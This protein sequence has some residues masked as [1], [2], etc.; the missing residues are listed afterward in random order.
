MTTITPEEKRLTEIQDTIADECSRLERGDDARLDPLWPMLDEMTRLTEKLDTQGIVL[1]EQDW[2]QANERRSYVTYQLSRASSF[3]DVRA[4]I[5][6]AREKRDLVALYLIAEAYPANSVPRA[7]A[8]RP[9]YDT[10]ATRIKI[11][12]DA[13]RIE[14]LRNLSPEQ[15]AET[16]ALRQGLPTVTP[17]EVLARKR[18]HFGNL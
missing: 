9:L 16:Y 10:R 11:R 14:Q 6:A 4:L 15:R 1:D 7:M 18:A 13:G 12:Q 3:D 17:D 2:Q 5:E 8:E